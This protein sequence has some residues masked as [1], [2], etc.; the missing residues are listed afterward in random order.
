MDNH[1]RESLAIHAGQ[2]VRGIDGVFVDLVYGD[3]SRPGKSVFMNLNR[4]S[5]SLRLT[6][7]E[8]PH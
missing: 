6:M 4:V 2:M 8:R 7:Y 1:T 3:R 5:L